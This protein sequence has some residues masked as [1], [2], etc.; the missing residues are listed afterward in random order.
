MQMYADGLARER[1]EEKRGDNAKYDDDDDGG[2]GAYRKPI[3]FDEE[4][5]ERVR[6]RPCV[7]ATKGEAVTLKEHKCHASGISRGAQGRQEAGSFPVYGY[8]WSRHAA[9]NSGHVALQN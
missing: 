3:N 2:G 1:D 9:G 4:G 6:D 5:V 8:D 7:R